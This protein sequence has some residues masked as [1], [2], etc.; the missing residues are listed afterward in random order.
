MAKKHKVE[1]EQEEVTQDEAQTEAG[2]E[3]HIAEVEAAQEEVSELVEG[4][5]VEL[6]I[7]FKEEVVEPRN[8][9]VAIKSLEFRPRGKPGS[10]RA[11]GVYVLEAK[12]ALEI[13]EAGI[14]SVIEDPC[15]ADLTFPDLDPEE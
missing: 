2:A 7:S 1:V 13:I 6:D 12:E 4:G 8:I 10:Y 15:K 11:G 14:A 9:K 3:A 5:P